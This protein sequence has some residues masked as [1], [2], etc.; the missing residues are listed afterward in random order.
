MEARQI[1][2]IAGSSTSSY[3]AMVLD[4]ASLGFSGAV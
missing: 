1:A 2:M 3:D 4:V